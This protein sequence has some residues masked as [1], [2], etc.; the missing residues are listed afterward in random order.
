MQDRL[1]EQHQ[2]KG[3]MKRFVLSTLAIIVLYAAILTPVDLWAQSDILINQSVLPFVLDVIMLIVNYAFYW[4]AFSF[5]IYAVFRLGW[6]GARSHMLAYALLVLGRY[7]ANV[8]AAATVSGWTASDFLFN[9]EFILYDIF[10][11]LILLG[12]VLLI[13]RGVVRNAYWMADGEKRV[14]MLADQ[15]PTERFFALKKPVSRT[16][17]FAAMLPSAVQILSRMTWDLFY[18]VPS[19]LAD[20]LWMILYYLSDVASFFIGFLVMM[21]ILA[22]LRRFEER[23]SEEYGGY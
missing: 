3:L 7:A 17:F 14:A 23:S 19:N 10:G 18:G 4:S 11:D 21:L 13:L 16:A 22:S 15:L 1:L 5:V 2:K 20:L 12:I 9:L 6:R 8:T